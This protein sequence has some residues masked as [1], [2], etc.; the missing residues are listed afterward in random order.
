LQQGQP[1]PLVSL[2]Q[3][4]NFRLLWIGEAVSLLGDQFQF[5]ALPWLVL[6]LTG[7][8]MAIGTVMALAGVPR[9]LFMLIGGALTDRFSPRRVMLASNAARM[10][11]VLGLALLVLGNVVSL[12]MPYLFAL[13]F[14]LADAFFYPAQSSI[15]PHIVDRE[16]LQLANSV[17]QGTAQ[18]SLFA[19]PLLAGTLIAFMSRGSAGTGNLEGIAL[20]FFVDTLTFLV[21]LVTLGAMRVEADRPPERESE[22][23]LRAI[24]EGLRYVWDDAV[25]RTIFL[26]I[27]AANISSQR[28]YRSA[29]R[30]RCWAVS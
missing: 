17:M 11:L 30:K 13:A 4:R 3:I 7:D 2:P 27:A 23:V 29:L 25:L 28:G 18:I 26:L 14:G 6:Q 24:A 5:I 19:G 15:I 12:W 16:H 20:A 10:V 9:A 1:S 21:S 22:S 8:G